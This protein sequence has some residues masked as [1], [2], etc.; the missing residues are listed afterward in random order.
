MCVKGRALCCCA[1]ASAHINI[2]HACRLDTSACRCAPTHLR[3]NNDLFL[4]TL[5]DE[6]PYVPDDAMCTWLPCPPRAP[7]PAGDCE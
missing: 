1:A 4:Q 7:H 5:E 2:Q 3:M 6:G